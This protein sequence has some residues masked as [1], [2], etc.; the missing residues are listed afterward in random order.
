MTMPMTHF[1]SDRNIQIGLLMRGVVIAFRDRIFGGAMRG[2]HAILS[3][4]PGR[5]ARRPAMPVRRMAVTADDATEEAR[6]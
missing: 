4:K 3:S 5:M 2:H 1:T 6:L